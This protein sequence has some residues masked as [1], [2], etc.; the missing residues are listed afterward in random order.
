MS[1]L[2][3]AEITRDGGVATCS[4]PVILARRVGRGVYEV[5]GLDVDRFATIVVWPKPLSAEDCAFLHA[6]LSPNHRT[7]YIYAGVSL[8]GLRVDGDGRLRWEVETE[9]VDA[10]FTVVVV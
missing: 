9:A 3:Y 2:A 1:F 8:D 10:D 4:P 5:G 6:A 7:I